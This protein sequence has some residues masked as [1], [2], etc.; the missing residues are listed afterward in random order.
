[1]SRA[2]GALSH[3]ATVSNRDTTASSRVELWCFFLKT[4]MCGVLYLILVVKMLTYSTNQKN[5]KCIGYIVLTFVE[6]HKVRQVPVP[7]AQNLPKT[8]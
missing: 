6:T 3:A 1:M 4:C 2:A 7:S 8:V 5:Y